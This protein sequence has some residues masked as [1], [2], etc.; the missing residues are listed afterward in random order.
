MK[1]PEY[2]SQIQMSKM[3]YDKLLCPLR[4]RESK[5]KNTVSDLRTE[6]ERDYHRIIGSA[7]F[8]RLQDKTQV[9]ALDKSDF[10]RTRLTHSLEVS[11]F[12]KSLGQTTGNM[13]C[14]KGVISGQQARDMSDILLCAG[15]IHD[16]GNPP[17][18]HFGEMVIRDWYKKNLRGMYFSGKP[19]TELISPL[20]EADLYC[21]EGNAQSLRVVAKLHH[22]VNDNGMNLTM[23]VLNTII[24]YPVSSSQI[25]KSAGDIRFKKMGYFQADK[26]LFE[27]VTGATGAFSYRHP[28]T[29]LLEAADDIAYSTA[30]I[31]DGFKKGILSYQALSKLLEEGE[32][33]RAAYERLETLYKRALDN[34]EYDPESYA[35]QN[36]VISMQSRLIQAASESFV[37]HQEEILD[38]AFGREVL[39]GT[40]CEALIKLLKKISYEHIFQ[41]PS[42]VRS[43]IAADTIISRLMDK[44]VPA[45]IL[46]D[47]REERGAAQKKL[48]QI[49]SRNYLRHYSLM[50]R[51][52][53]DGDKLYLRLVL[54]NDFIAGMTDSYAKALYQEL[55]GVSS[56]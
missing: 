50:A 48:M 12:A 30:D 6:F 53:T 7:S 13:L 22:L 27:T 54:V 33:G 56:S 43:E 14:E 32:G 52:A 51:E 15:L 9:F 26:E 3:S 18:G 46:Y 55:T 37:E 5:K 17:F 35:V 28:L 8:R 40:D 25:D 31:E 45:A 42:I 36:W 38:G 39:E 29:F 16:I 21:F 2:I 44:L 11:S 23:G 1:R 10:V 47:T 49:V 34:G 4:M 24:K 20:Q 41:T 19:V